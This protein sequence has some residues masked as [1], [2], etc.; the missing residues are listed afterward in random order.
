MIKFDQWFL[1]DGETHLQ[2]W[3]R[4]TRRVVKGRFTYQFEKLEAALAFVPQWRVAVDVGAHAGLWS[5]WLARNFEHLHAFEPSDKHREC[6]IQNMLE[7]S[8]TT[9][10]AYALGDKAGRVSLV[11]GPSSSGDTHVVVDDKA[12]IHMVTLDSLELTNVDFIKVDVEG[13]EYQ[14][15]KG[16][17]ETLK[18]EKPVVIVEQKGHEHRYFGAPPQQALGYLQTLGMAPMAK[19]MSG[20]F[21]MGWP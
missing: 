21:I 20:D 17:V 9:L 14:V 16:A 11:T 18:R 8:N 6:W 7:F 19:P 12:E 10:H 3:M 15:L 4:Q 5:Y 2:D 1:P 13:F